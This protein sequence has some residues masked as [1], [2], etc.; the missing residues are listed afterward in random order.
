MTTV[1]LAEKWD[2]AKRI[3]AVVGAASQLTGY[4]EGNGYV[5]T[6]AAGHL[7]E[8]AEPHQIEPRW[9]D[10]CFEDL[11]MSPASWPLVPINEKKRR[12]QLEIVCRLLRDARMTRVIAATDAAREGEEIF[13][14][15]YEYAGCNL[16]VERLW[17]QSVAPAEIQAK[18]ADL[19]PG[20]DYDNLAKAARLRAILDWLVGLNATRLYSKAYRDRLG[21][22][23][24]YSL[25]RVQ[26][27]TLRILVDRELAIRD[28]VPEPYLEVHATFGPVGP[29]DPPASSRY[30]GIYERPVVADAEGGVAPARLPADGSAADAVLARAR[31]GS[32]RIQSIESKERKSPP[33]QLHDLADLQKQGIRV[34]GLTAKAVLDAAQ[35]LYEQGLLTYPRTDSRH[36]SQPVADE[37]SGVVRQIAPHYDGLVA[38]RS[39][40]EPLSKRFVNDAKVTDHHAIIPTSAPVDRSSLSARD[41]GIYDLVCRRL[42]SAWHDDS[43]S[44]TTTVVT[45]VRAG[46]EPPDHYRSQGTTL[47]QLGWKCLEPQPKAR[48]TRRD[49]PPL[50]PDLAEGQDQRVLDA[51]AVEK[52][53]RPPRRLDEATLLTAMANAGESLE[54][55]ELSGAMRERG[56]GTPATRDRMIET[57]I[58][59]G[60]VS[61]DKKNILTA[62]QKGIEVVGFAHPHLTSPSLTGQWEAALHRVERGEMDPEVL[63]DATRTYVQALVDSVRDRACA[64]DDRARALGDHV[65]A[66]LV[67]HLEEAGPSASISSSALHRNAFESQGVSR[68]EFNDAVR[69][70]VR[71]GRVREREESFMKGKRKKRYRALCLPEKAA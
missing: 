1:I 33:P 36:L 19:R 57:L 41:L 42:L 13:R 8:L 35:A 16:P 14:R 40:V 34:L 60:Y 66:A 15:I 25:G 12:A 24:F 50:P 63:L 56:L 61:R 9:K 39:G 49:E 10:W 70:L 37:L 67:S 64:L 69:S 68:Q 22:G 3:A 17:L 11:P 32:A 2:V 62:T 6:S 51:E 23:D 7:V 71:A 18:L 46:E 52:K 28:F 54:D 4:F 5:V 26:S 58:A 43:I 59:R 48:S 27:P 65:V 45:E 20:S 21:P 29:D 55:R 47:L 53:T 38:E 30:Q 44:A 31:S